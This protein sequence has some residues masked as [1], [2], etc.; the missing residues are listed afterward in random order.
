MNLKE[1]VMI[2][3]D[4]C[5]DLNNDTIKQNNIGIA[6][7]SSI[8]GNT[9]EINKDGTLSNEELFELLRQGHKVTTSCPSI[10]EYIKLFNDGLENYE[11]ITHFNMSGELS[12]SY[13][14][15]EIAKSEVDPKRITIFDTRQVSLGHTLQVLN[16]I[17]YLDELT[18]LDELIQTIKSD[19]SRTELCVILYTA[20]YVLA[21]G[22][23]QKLLGPTLGNTIEKA[24]GYGFN[25]T[26]KMNIRYIVKTKDGKLVND[27]ITRGSEIRVATNCFGNILNNIENV[28]TR[29]IVLGATSDMSVLD[30]I[31]QDVPNMAQIQNIEKLRAGTVITI[32]AGP[33]GVAMAYTRKKAR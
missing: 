6:Y 9:G 28:D 18:S 31:V 4:S 25:I 21:G 22:R 11:Y 23:I 13:Q 24:L 33:R 29:R 3:S 10:D 7:L 2:T 27:K 14:N 17:E 32:H 1:K 30:K 19:I 15:A 8:N 26:D 16:A 5:A 20:K 12:A